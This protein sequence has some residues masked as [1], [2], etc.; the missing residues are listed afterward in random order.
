MTRE[1]IIRPDHRAPPTVGIRTDV[2][3]LH[4]DVDQFLMDAQRMPVVPGACSRTAR[5]TNDA[6][7]FA[8]ARP[9]P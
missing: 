9:P 6:R 2:V 3:D 4:R 7:V 8:L 1:R 5:Q